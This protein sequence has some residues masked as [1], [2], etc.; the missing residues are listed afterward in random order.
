[1]YISTVAGLTY[2]RVKNGRISF[3]PVTLRVIRYDIV[4]YC[5]NKV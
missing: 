1:M 2:T 4:F 3:H 5:S